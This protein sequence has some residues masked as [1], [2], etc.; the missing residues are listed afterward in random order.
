MSGKFIHIKSP[1]FPILPGEDD[2]IVNEGMYGKALA[3]YLLT[4][5]GERGYEVPFVYAEDWGWWVE[6]AG[7]PFKAGVCIYSA[8]E[9]GKP[10]EYVCTDSTLKPRQWSWSRFRF[11]DVQPWSDKITGDL[12]NI[13][14]GDAEV[15]LVGVT[16]EFPF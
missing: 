3:E 15:Q 5:L 8:S 16:D 10:D 4:K 2:E 1:K 12:I 9:H 14:D 7:E 6:I 13:F 11:I